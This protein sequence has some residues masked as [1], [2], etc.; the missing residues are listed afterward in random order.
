LGCIEWAAIK[1]LW[2]ID[3]G[4]DL[5]VVVVVSGLACCPLGFTT[6]LHVGLIEFLLLWG[7]AVEV[8]PLVPLWG[9]IHC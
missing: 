6:G 1:V 5:V 2:V 4:K 8:A 7:I 3:V 9:R